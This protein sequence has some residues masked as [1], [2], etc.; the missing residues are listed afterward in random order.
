MSSQIS[1]AVTYNAR[2]AR[3]LLDI[4]LQSLQRKHKHKPSSPNPILLFAL[5]PSPATTPEALSD[6]T[7]TLTQLYPEHV[8]CISAPLPYQYF[9]LSIC[10]GPHSCSLAYALVNGVSFRS[11]ISGRA[12]AQVGRWHAARQR[13]TEDASGAI[14]VNI[15][16]SQMRII[17]DS[18]RSDGKVNWEDV[19]DRT[20]NCSSSSRHGN[21][22][23]PEILPD[24]LRNLEYVF[25]LL[26]IFLCKCHVPQPISHREYPLLL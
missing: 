23:D 19:W 8:G 5:A 12:E 26:T 21:G 17:T 24:A 9:D 1:A 16:D 14:P 2:C 7:S 4:L 11:T 15:E 18:S 25:S 6:I 13:I 20:A 22:L 3:S 10:G